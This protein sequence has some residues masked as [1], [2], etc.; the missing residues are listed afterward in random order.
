M[1]LQN[2]A[3]LIEDIF[4]GKVTGQTEIPEQSFPHRDLADPDGKQFNASF[5]LF[6]QAVAGL[7]EADV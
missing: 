1:L 6:T 4:D 5:A 2:G 3:G 7:G